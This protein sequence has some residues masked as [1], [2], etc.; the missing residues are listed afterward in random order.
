MKIVRRKSLSFFAKYLP[1]QM[2]A[3]EERTR[4]LE[5]LLRQGLGTADIES[6]YLP[7]GKQGKGSY[8]GAN[9][10]RNVK[11]VHLEMKDRCK[12]AHKE[13]KNCRKKRSKI[14][15]KF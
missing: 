9:I 14:R 12:Q 13:E 7:K 5:G 1:L 4:L 8:R 6:R 3:A 10:P 2:T 15:Q 11:V